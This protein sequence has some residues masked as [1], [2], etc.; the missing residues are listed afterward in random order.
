MSYEIIESLINVGYDGKLIDENKFSE[1]LIN[2]GFK[3]ED[4]RL[5][6]IWLCNEISEDLLCL[7]RKTH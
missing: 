6:I 3:N 1:A 4:F 7:I 5:L 2:D